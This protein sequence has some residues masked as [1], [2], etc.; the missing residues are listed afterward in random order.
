MHIDTGNSKPQAQIPYRTNFEN[1]KVIEAEIHRMEEL[2]YLRPSFSP[3]ASPVVLVYK[4]DV[5]GVV[6]RSKPRLVSDYTRINNVTVPIV[7]HMLNTNDILEQL[8]EADLYSS[9]DLKESYHQIK[10]LESDIPKT[11]ITSHCGSYEFLVANYGLKNSGAFLQK[12][13]NIVL[14]GLSADWLLSFIDDILIYSGKGLS[15]DDHINMLDR[16]LQRLAE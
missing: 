14:S 8:S 6:N 7:H 1:R 12:A 16:T 5:N 15:E 4:K 10:M 11:A 3:W 2:G 9:I 13:L